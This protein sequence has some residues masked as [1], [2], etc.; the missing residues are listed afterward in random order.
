M[1]GAL[2]SGDDAVVDQVLT[3]VAGLILGEPD[4]TAEWMPKWKQLIANSDITI[5]GGALLDRDDV[6]DRL[7]EVACPVLIVHGTEDQAITL[8]QARVVADGVQDCRGF[9][10]VP[11]AAHAANLSHPEVVNP[12]LAVF[13][14]EL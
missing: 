8:D 10:E 12:P 11:G 13:L 14:A 4:L 1:L 6:T 7:G 3:G 2:T 5:A 9:V